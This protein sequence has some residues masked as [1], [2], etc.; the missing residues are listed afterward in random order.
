M[1]P[2]FVAFLFSK[3]ESTI[4]V[5]CSLLSSFVVVSDV[6]ACTSVV[7]MASI[8]I[9]RYAALHFHTR[10]RQ[11]ITTKR[12]ELFLALA[13]LPGPLVAL[14]GLWNMTLSVALFI[15]LFSI[16]FAV[17][18]LVYLKIYR[19]LNQISRKRHELAERRAYKYDL[20]RY[21]RVTSGMI[22]INIA[23]ILC[24]LPFGCTMLFVR[25]RGPTATKQCILEFSA[26]I[27]H[28]NA[29]LN[30]LSYAFNLPGV[31]RN[32]SRRLQGY[33]RCRSGTPIRQD[34]RIAR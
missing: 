25:F 20:I 30:P 34:T 17:I 6:L 29:C 22:W 5:Q 18:F 33:L 27:I 13:W 31:R 16:S 24:Y 3:L 14:S 2:L 19:R 28:L 4:D 9:D 11:V 26:T 1:Q 10:Y 7:L 21:R 15:L 32:I 8:S 12:V 23:F